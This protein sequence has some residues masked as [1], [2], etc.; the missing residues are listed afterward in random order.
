MPPGR[1]LPL[2]GVAPCSLQKPP[3]HVLCVRAVIT[4]SQPNYLCSAASLQGSSL[5]AEKLPDTNQEKEKLVISRVRAVGSVHSHRL[6][7]EGK[8]DSCNK[9]FP[10]QLGTIP[11]HT[12]SGSCS[13]TSSL[14]VACQV[15]GIP[16]CIVCGKV[17]LA[18]F[19]GHRSGAWFILQRQ[20]VRK[21][22]E[23]TAWCCSLPSATWPCWHTGAHQWISEIP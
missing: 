9:P 17:P 8:T 19:A 23:L 7:S 6:Q 22:L 10:S 12:T 13:T 1:C 14:W 18:M 2:T 21:A 11:A 3:A 4:M 15:G 16:S 20:E 5:K